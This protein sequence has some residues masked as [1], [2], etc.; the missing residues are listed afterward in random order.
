MNKFSWQRFEAAPIVGIIRN[1]PVEPI[2]RI[3]ALYAEGGLTTLEITL[4]TPGAAD[5]IHQLQ[6]SIG[7]VLNIGAGTVCSLDE[8]DIALN[9][10]ASFIV[11]PIIEEEVIKKC[12][13]NGIPVFPGAFTPS[14]IYRAW[15]LGAE[16][17]KL[18]PATKMGP[19]YIKEVLAPLN[20]I[21]LMPTGGVSPENCE[22]FF[23]AGASAVGMGSNLFPKDLIA[24]SDWEGLRVI[25]KQYGEM[26]RRIKSAV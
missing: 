7:D 21:K 13:A 10:G 6:N 24:A 12:V 9:A 8:L 14:E 11:T 22:A 4:N 20:K 26:I 1:V 15:S 5:V 17:I 25:Y 19:D 3:A 23:K 2:Q 16:M 18:F